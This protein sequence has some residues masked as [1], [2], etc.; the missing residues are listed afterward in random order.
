[1]AHDEGTQEIDL[2]ELSAPRQHAT[3][4]VIVYDGDE[5]GAVHGLTR[6]ETVF[7]R[8]GD[9]DVVVPH[10][11]VS[12]RHAL[13]RRVA[14][15]SQEYEVVDLNS[16][17]GTFLNGEAVQ[18][19]RLSE[20]DKIKIGASTLKFAVLDEA[21]ISFQARIVEMIH[22]DDLTGLLTKRSLYR[23]LEKELVRAQRYARPVG[24]LMMDLDFFKQINDTHG[25]LVGSHCL[26][27]VGR[28]IRDTTRTVDVNG[29]YGGE[30]FVSY[31]P[32]TSLAESL[33]VAE[34]I[35]SALASR[36]FRHDETIYQ[37]RISI[38]V[39]AFPIHGATV[40]ELVH[41]A[42]LALYRAKADGRN[43]VVAYEPSLVGIG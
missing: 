19:A 34:R 2:A 4:S 23:A 6:D 26:A 38:G 30:E 22:V 21:D 33:L 41:A 36:W 28:V 43:K 35:R 12:R 16:T 31:L 37:V 20:G 9:C 7:G 42:D 18:R 40:E 1:V 13:I 29:R 10:D 15:G 27:E 25:H 32:E 5:I 17:N 14:P 3:A 11:N 39:S 24:V 8:T